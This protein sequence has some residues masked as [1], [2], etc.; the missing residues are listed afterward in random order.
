MSTKIE[1]KVKNTVSLT[2]SV[3]WSEFEKAIQKSYMK[4]RSRFNINGFRKGKA[5]RKLIEK[6]YG[7]EIFY[8]DAINFVLPEAYD[9][10]VDELELHP[11]DRPTVDFEEIVKGEDVVFKVDVDVKPEVELNEYKGIEAVKAEYTVTDEDVDNEVKRMQEQN[12]RIIEIEDRDVKDGDVLT[13]DFEG[14]I[15]GEK[16]DGGTAENHSLTIGSGAFIPGFEEQ[17]I[18]KKKDD[19][20]DVKVTFPEDYQ[21][22]D[23]A[24]KEAVFKVTIHEVKERELPVLDDEFAKDVSEFDTLAELKEDIKNRLQEQADTKAKNETENNV[25][26]SVVD[27]VEI[28]IP[29]AMIARQVESEVRELDYRLR[30]Q[31]LDVEKYLQFTNGSMEDLKEQMKPNAEKVVKAELVL[32]EIS[33]KEGIEATDEELDKELEKMAKQYNQELEALKKNIKEQEIEYIK[34]G[35]IKSKTVD[36]LVENAN[37][38]E[39]DK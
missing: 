37:Y 38:K 11:V 19:V 10:A 16:F 3:E 26:A 18:G 39:A 23:L 4:N 27:S 8:D 20:V 34:L 31:G 13:I 30:Y 29:E 5:P 17:L 21:A 24:G 15:D 14:S 35:I 33:K 32:E 12:A 6:M 25:I 7:I 9:N 36:F 2:I 22:E 28:D 1:K